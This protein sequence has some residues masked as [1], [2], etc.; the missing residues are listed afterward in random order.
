MYFASNE[1]GGFC[2]EKTVAINFKIVRRICV[3]E[4]NKIRLV[5]VLDCIRTRH[6][7]RTQVRRV[8]SCSETHQSQRNFHATLP[9]STQS[10]SESWTHNAQGSCHT[11]WLQSGRRGR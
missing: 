5:R 6:L 9:N 3:E 8:T 1:V 10:F 11:A 7:S 2:R 4:L